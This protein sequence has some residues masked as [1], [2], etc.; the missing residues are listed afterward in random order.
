VSFEAA[1]NYCFLGLSLWLFCTG[2]R[3]II[4]LMLGGFF[5]AVAF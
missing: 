5:L 2:K 4:L 3:R 1:C